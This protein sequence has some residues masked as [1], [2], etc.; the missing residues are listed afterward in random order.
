MKRHVLEIFL[1]ALPLFCFPSVG[2]TH[3]AGDDFTPEGA[4][5][6]CRGVVEGV[7][8][9]HG[10]DRFLEQLLRDASLDELEA[11]FQG[12]KHPG[13][14][15]MAVF[16]IGGADVVEHF[17]PRIRHVIEKRDVNWTWALPAVAVSCSNDEALAFLLNQGIDVNMSRPEVADLMMAAVINL[18]IGIVQTLFDAGYRRCPTLPSGETLLVLAE[19]LDFGAFLPLYEKYCKRAGR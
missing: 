19:R 8:R 14:A 12:S 5:A 11:A 4:A 18:D 7:S 13:D 3:G 17:W 9:R 6:F 1:A 16:Q 10:G 15:A 2:L